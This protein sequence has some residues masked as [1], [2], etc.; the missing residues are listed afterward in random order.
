MEFAESTPVSC[1]NFGK[2]PFLQE[3]P[4]NLLL[5][6]GPGWGEVDKRPSGAQEKEAGNLKGKGNCQNLNYALMRSD[7]LI[8]IS[9]FQLTRS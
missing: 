6:V 5:Q 4:Q 8:F 9:K 1:S 3:H 2:F 7:Q